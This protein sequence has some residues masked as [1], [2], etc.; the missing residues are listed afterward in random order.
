M[1]IFRAPLLWAEWIDH[2]AS[3][4]IYVDNLS[5]RQALAKKLRSEGF[6]QIHILEGKADIA[7]DFAK[8]QPQFVLLDNN[9]AAV[10]STIIDTAYAS[11]VKKVLLLAS[12]L[13][14]PKELDVPF[15][16]NELLGKKK[17]KPSPLRVSKLASLRKL[18]IYNTLPGT[19]YLLCIHPY[20]YSNSINYKPLEA[21][22]LQLLVANIVKE[23]Q[24][25]SDIVVINEHP[26]SKIELLHIDDLASALVFLLH[27]PVA[28]NCINV[29]YGNDVALSDLA[30]LICLLTKFKG[31][32]FF[33]PAE[34][35]KPARYLLDS[36][37]LFN[38]GWQPSIPLQPPLAEYIEN[39]QKSLPPYDPLK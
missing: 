16:E 22:A 32:I 29:G 30:D 36:S 11:Q 27:Q 5:V 7:A 37:R 39:Y 10:E 3:I 28:E 12:F 6:T 35:Q 14:Y 1:L 13:I 23:Q 21:H 2:D 17:D 33:N 15:K 34:A 31:K 20:L 19:Q 9:D 18:Q 8:L 26:E 24:K 38:L 4:C 25:N